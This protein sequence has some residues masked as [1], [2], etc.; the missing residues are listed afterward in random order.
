MLAKF[1][2]NEMKQFFFEKKYQLKKKNRKLNVAKFVMKEKE[3]FLFIIAGQP[4]FL[5]NSFT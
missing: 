1:R 3:Y 2:Q 4:N 5:F